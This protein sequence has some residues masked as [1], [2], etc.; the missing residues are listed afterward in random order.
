MRDYKIHHDSRNFMRILIS[1]IQIGIYSSCVVNWDLTRLLFTA[2][3]EL[4]KVVVTLAAQLIGIHA[5]KSVL[6]ACHRL[7]QI[8][9]KQ[10]T[11]FLFEKNEI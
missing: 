8:S 7:T 9:W 11:V 4:Y 1:C 3:V 6:V 2:T 5:N 10:P